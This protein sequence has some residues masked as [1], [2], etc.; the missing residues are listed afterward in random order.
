MV[1]RYKE[2]TIG[3]VDKVSNSPERK[4]SSVMMVIAPFFLILVNITP[5]SPFSVCTLI[6]RTGMLFIKVEVKRSSERSFFAS[7][8]RLSKCIAKENIKSSNCLE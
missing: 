8:E 3:S 6:L 4:A 7:S 1:A 5:S 2:S